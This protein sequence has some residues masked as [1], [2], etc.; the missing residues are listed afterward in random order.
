MSNLNQNDAR[1]VA[2][3]RGTQN[4]T[5]QPVPGREPSKA[6]YLEKEKMNAAAGGKGLSA[7]SEGPVKAELLDAG[8]LGK[9]AGGFRANEI[10]V[11]TKVDE[12]KI[13]EKIESKRFS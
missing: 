9:A 8:K 6:Q 10:K 7:K 12:Q 11:E 5:E 3:G 4:A 1:N 2:G 13:S